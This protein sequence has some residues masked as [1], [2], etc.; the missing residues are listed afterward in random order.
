VTEGLEGRAF[1]RKSEAASSLLFASMVLAFGG[2]MAFEGLFGPF[3]RF[4]GVLWAI[5]FGAPFIALSAVVITGDVW[6]EDA[7]KPGKW[8]MPHKVLVGVVAL[9]WAYSIVARLTPA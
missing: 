2:A 5:V 8:G 1:Y 9:V 7:A 3:G 6:R 4:A